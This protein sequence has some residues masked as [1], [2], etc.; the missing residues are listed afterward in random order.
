MVTRIK[1]VSIYTT[2]RQNEDIEIKNEYNATLVDNVLNFVF[3]YKIF[4]EEVSDLTG[5]ILWFKHM[6]RDKKIKNIYILT[7]YDEWINLTSDG[8]LLEESEN[9]LY[10]RIILD[11]NKD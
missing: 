11:N 4:N 9:P 7:D 8:Y 2:D 3:S 6:I 1:K 10:F 5:T